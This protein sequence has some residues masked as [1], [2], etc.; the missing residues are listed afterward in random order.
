MLKIQLKFKFQPIEKEEE[1]S[2][3]EI[4]T[5][6]MEDSLE[7]REWMNDQKGDSPINLFRVFPHPEYRWDEK[8]LMPSEMTF[9][10]KGLDL[11]LHQ[12]HLTPTQV[13]LK[14]NLILNGS[15]RFVFSIFKNNPSFCST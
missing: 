12:S 14:I 9:H 6:W 11:S 10:S 8:E 15:C 1:T 5:L 4:D 13:C 7:R 2:I 3:L